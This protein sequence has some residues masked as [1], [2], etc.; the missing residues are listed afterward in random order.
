MRPFI[1]SAGV[2]GASA[3]GAPAPTVAGT[4]V[5]APPPRLA[6]GHSGDLAKENLP[7]AFTIRAVPE[8]H[9]DDLGFLSWA[10][11][12]GTNSHVPPFA[13]GQSHR[14]RQPLLMGWAL[15][16]TPTPSQPAEAGIPGAR[17]GVGECP[18]LKAWP[19]GVVGPKFAVHFRNPANAEALPSL[20]QNPAICIPRSGSGTRR[21]SFFPRS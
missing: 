1:R 13:H 18:P 6:D 8:H 2:A 4:G 20:G 12:G 17:R 5:A 15:V 10:G 7:A 3:E 16:D 11:T 19:P 21:P 14:A 9:T